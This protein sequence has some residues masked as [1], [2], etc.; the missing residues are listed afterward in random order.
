MPTLT[1]RD[2]PDRVYERLKERAGRHRRSLSGEIVTLL[3]EKLLPQRLD[4]EALIAEVE[5]FHA[6]FDEPLPDLA[7]EGKRA[8]RKY[9]DDLVQ[10]DVVQD[11]V[12]GNDPAGGAPTEGSP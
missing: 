10:D 1:V 12:A 6:R 11:D 2:I 4:T 8:G 5:A 9:E 7:A 3:E